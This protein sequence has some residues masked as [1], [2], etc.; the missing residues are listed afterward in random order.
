MEPLNIHVKEEV[1]EDPDL[2]TTVIESLD[3]NVLDENTLL[4]LN[5][6]KPY[7]EKT[8]NSSENE[9]SSYNDVIKQDSSFECNNCELNDSPA[10]LVCPVGKH[11]QDSHTPVKSDPDEERKPEATAD[12]MASTGSHVNVK[13]E[14]ADPC[15]SKSLIDAGGI[16]ADYHQDQLFSDSDM[17]DIIKTEDV[18]EHNGTLSSDKQVQQNEPGARKAKILPICDKNTEP[19]VVTCKDVSDTVS[20]YSIDAT[21][22]SVSQ[23]EQQTEGGN[24]DRAS[25]IP[26]M[27][28]AC[29]AD[30]KNECQLRKHLESHAN[31]KLY[32]CGICRAIFN[33][34][35]S[36]KEHLKN[37]HFIP[38]QQNESE[39]HE[40]VTVSPPNDQLHGKKMSCIKTSENLTCDACGATLHSVASL[41][42]HLRNHTRLNE[43]KCHICSDQFLSKE[44]LNIHIRNH[45]GEKPFI[46]CSVCDAIFGQKS[47]LN[48]HMKVHRGEKPY[49][50]RICSMAFSQPGSLQ[51]HLPIHADKKPLKCNVCGNGFIRHF[52]LAQHL[53]AVHLREKS[54]LCPVCGVT[55]ASKANL[56]QH[57]QIHSSEK[58]FK[59]NICASAFKRNDTLRKHLRKHTGEKPFACSICGKT[60]SQRY[61]HS[62]HVK[63]HQ[64]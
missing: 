32:R 48:R 5:G 38:F 9:R 4:G 23:P 42:S 1:K 43:H 2:G 41:R 60:F 27:C 34:S 35:S 16:L 63:L 47:H 62:Q 50:C 51:K 56:R 58:K 61:S 45:T 33:W 25:K 12:W 44:G 13:T 49:Q 3:L 22:G 30:F 14:P 24:E 55:F 7:T 6:D 11:T 54:V 40:E 57:S 26:F 28:N 59:C 64:K 29:G 18:A 37:M 21:S 17:K 39:Q 46:K 52:D 15:D 53:R 8:G 31:V 36:L 20:S 19:V 10:P